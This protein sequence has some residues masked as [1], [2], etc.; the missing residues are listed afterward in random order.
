MGSRWGRLVAVATLATVSPVSAQ[1]VTELGVQATTT[2]SDPALAVVGPTGAVRL[3]ERGRLALA[4]GAGVSDGSAAWRA[5]ALG[6][7]LL[8]PRRRTG[9]AAYGG[10]GVAAVGGPVD[11][12]YLVLALGLESA[13]GRQAGWFAEIGAGGGVRLAVGWRWR[14]FPPGWELTD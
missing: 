6:H 2:L 13:P 10:A 8:A 5:E 12:G 7:F 3:S 9:A 11:R 4:V 14:R 1:R